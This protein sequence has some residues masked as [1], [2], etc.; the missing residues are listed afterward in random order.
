MSLFE[1]S[2]KIRGLH[3]S[4]FFHFVVLVVAML[5]VDF[6]KVNHEQVFTVDILPIK[7][8]SNIKNKADLNKAQSKLLTQKKFEDKKE[9]EKKEEEKK[10]EKPKK[11]EIAPKEQKAIKED[12]KSDSKKELKKDDK[13]KDKNQ[14]DKK[15]DKQK[16][17]T[18][19]EKKKEKKRKEEELDALLKDL[20]DTTQELN[21]LTEQLQDKEKP[22]KGP[23]DPDMELSMGQMDFI[24]KQIEDKWTKSPDYTNLKVTL[25]INIS[26]DGTIENVKVKT[27]D[28]ASNVMYGPFVESAVRAV[29]LASPL[30]VSVLDQAEFH[31]WQ[32][33]DFNFYGD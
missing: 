2:L 1:K 26:L 22:S 15:L 5:A 19:P 28:G 16:K 21:E 8:F 25:R 18:K 31:K 9:E 33:F 10:L 29:H 32:E 3:F 30:D 24:R 20:E 12:K 23:Y 14:N 4:L 13:R 7:E 11:E 27:R 6:R 17:Q